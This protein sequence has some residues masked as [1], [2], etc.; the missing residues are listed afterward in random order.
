MR[1]QPSREALLQRIAELE[2][3][4]EK[5]RRER[6]PDGAGEALRDDREDLERKLAMATH[7]LETSDAKYRDLF[8]NAGDAIFIH[9]L[10]GTIINANQRALALFDYTK[11]EILAIKIPVLHPPQAMEKSRWA[12][13]KILREGHVRF[14]TDFINKHGEVIP[15]EVSSCLFEIDGQSVIQGIVR[16]IRERHL[17]EK[18][19][20]ETFAIIEKSPVAVFLWRNTADW[21]VE[22]VSQNVS[23]IFGY[24]AEAFL[25]GRVVYRDVV[26]PEDFDRVI[27]E[28]R[29]FSQE[30]CRLEFTH[31]PYRIVTEDGRIRWLND[32]TVIRRDHTGAITHFQGIVEDITDG[33]LAAIQLTAE[34]KR[35]AVTLRSIGDAVITT[36]REGRIELMNLVAE[37]LTGWP[38]SE[39]VGRPLLEVFRIFDERTREPCA[40]PTDQVIASG[41][42]VGRANHTLLVARD[43]REFY[44]EDSGAPILDDRGEIV[45]VVLV[46]RDTTERKQIDKELLKMEKLQSLG[47]LAGGLAHDF[48]N[49]L[50]GILGNLSLAKL[51]IKPN[52]SVARTLDEM[53]KAALRAKD[54]TQQLLTFSKGGIPVKD[55]V[56]IVELV[57]EATQFALRGSNVGYAL[58]ID[59]D[60]RP[61]EVDSGQMAQVFQ[62]LVINADQAMPDGGTITIRGRNVT[63]APDNI[64][65]LTPG[66]YV[67]LTINDQGLGIKADH[68]KKVFDPY[69]TTKQRGSGLGLAVAFSIIAKH[70]GH[71]TVDSKLGVGTTFTMLLPAAARAVVS[72]APRRRHLETGLGRILVMDD[73][74]FIR[75]LAVKMLDKIGYEAVVAP[76]GESAVILYREALGSGRAFDAVILDLTVPGGM[77]GKETLRQLAALD[78]DVRAIVSSGY[79][80][81]PVMAQ[82]NRYGFRGAVKKPYLV[83]EMSSVLKA[84]VGQRG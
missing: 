30:A 28:V 23:R 13:E 72:D 63:L 58:E 27:H 11:A 22:F 48:N 20:R 47:V 81:D 9:D 31:E 83:Q 62:N 74:D 76:D 5:R 12:F 53:E 26:H 15:A 24:S 66:E 3:A 35:L 36:N 73:E 82:F 37:D 59:K 61:A 19:R 32:H 78:P 64:Y 8:E 46:F 67:E 40:N 55:T 56:S 50:T 70:D 80:N 25:T 14:E 60:L 18:A 57:R 33:R 17:V 77:G 45:G 43:G 42:T 39:A 34:K 4:H 68:L 54:L 41:Q 10:E 2:A 1:K 49:F 65:A 6:A 69:F 79:S 7:A 75:T 44:I 29:T 51:D 71:L 84:V 16:D 38:E 21:P 52:D